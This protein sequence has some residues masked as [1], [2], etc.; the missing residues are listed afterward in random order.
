MTGQSVSGAARGGWITPLVFAGVLAA[1]SAWAQGLSGV[2]VA[3]NGGNTSDHFQDEIFIGAQ[4]TSVVALQPG[5]N[6]TT[7]TTRYAMVVST[8][9]GAFTNHSETLNADY[10]ITFTVT[11]PGSY[12]LT[13][14]S[15]RVG[16]L[17]L[18][19]DGNGSAA[20]TLGGV[21]GSQVGGFLSGS[22]GL[23]SVPTL[24]S[25]G[26]G[27]SPFSQAAVAT[28]TGISNGVPQVH[29]LTFSWS[30]SCTSTWATVFSTG[31]DE[32]AV[33]MGLPATYSGQSVGQYPGIGS[34]VQANDGHFVTVTFSSPCGDSVTDPGE[35]EE[36]DEGPANGTPGSCC[37]V[38]CSLKAAGTTCRG[39]AGGCDIA[40][41][42]DGIDGACPADV[43]ETVGTVCRA[44]S[45]GE[46]CDIDEVCDGVNVACPPDLV[47]PAG[48]VC[49][50]SA[51]D[52][53][54]EEECDGV[55][56]FCPADDVL[57][58]GTV[59]RAS[60]GVCD[61]DEECDGVDAQCPSDSFVTAGSVCRPSAGD[62]D[63][64]EQCTGSNAACPADSKATAG[65]VCRASADLCDAQEVCDGVNDDCPADGLEAA[66]TVC[67]A[68]AGACDIAEECDGVTA[69]CP[70]DDVVSAGTECRASAGECDVAEQC[71]GVDT[72]CPSDAFVADGTACTDD[73]LF[74]T[75]DETCQGGACVSSGD[76]CTVGVC[77]EDDDICFEDG[78]TTVPLACRTSQKSVMVIRDNP[79]ND[80]DRLI[81]R[82]TRGQSTDFAD[83]G[84]PA[85]TS[86]F[87]LCVYAGTTAALVAEAN[88]EP[89]SANWSV[90]GN[91]KGFRYK[92]NNGTQS[93]VQ[94]VIVKASANDRARAFVKGKGASL[95]D[96]TLPL[97]LPVLTQLVNQETGICF[98]STYLG[99]NVS[100]NTTGQF[101]AK[102]K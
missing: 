47:L 91:N 87:N 33:R 41:E 77:D 73:G 83:Y 42:C 30:S 9:T 62:C 15:S 82:W 102:V 10:T 88:V 56:T 63:A 71:D 28:I 4:R 64:E 50:A 1:S 98:E 68:A 92:D 19:D 21:T 67:R 37:N 89:N 11:A 55:D 40:E 38:N 20:A 79:N 36:C 54:I 101:K 26:G 61:L 31:G 8:D 75:G 34:R 13:V 48:T 95:P 84:N 5:A 23:A 32:C 60:A 99:P 97:A 51:G 39:A 25:G 81:W 70:A 80:R 58:A 76:P 29:T 93:G 72:Q 24:S 100:R 16:A 59:C 86:K 96:P 94:R 57:P 45:S 2:G 49:R 52:C 69:Q 7:F 3:K 27:N 90:I 17:T 35:N 53:D 46:L 18:V 22:L 65:T 6:A 12:T 66:G 85:T 43:V 14:N 74:C 78:C 44:A